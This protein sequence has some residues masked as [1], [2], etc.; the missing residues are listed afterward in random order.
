MK[1]II[2]KAIS[3]SLACVMAL[4]VANFSGVTAKADLVIGPQLFEKEIVNN[5]VNYEF[6]DGVLT[7]KGTGIAD[8]TYK[9]KP[10]EILQ[11]TFSS[12]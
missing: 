7:A 6:K 8:N 5:D 10:S 12:C 1:R 4:G 11:K 9:C 3:I 2:T